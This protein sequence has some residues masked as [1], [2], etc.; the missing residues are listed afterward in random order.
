MCQKPPLM[1]EYHLPAT[2]EPSR[3]SAQRT[4]WRSR[5]RKGSDMPLFGS[6]SVY[7]LCDTGHRHD[8][9]LAIEPNLTMSAARE[10]TSST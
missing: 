2:A 6:G 4:L 9:D 3:T 10:A 7:N 1:R 5:L 8:Q